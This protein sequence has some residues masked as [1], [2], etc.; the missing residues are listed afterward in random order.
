MAGII[1]ASDNVFRLASDPEDMM[2]NIIE[3]GTHLYDGDPESKRYV[4]HALPYGRYNERPDRRV[5]QFVYHAPSAEH[6]AELHE[7]HNP[8]DAIH[9]VQG[10]GDDYVDYTHPDDDFW[11]ER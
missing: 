4:V 5:E 11:P 2:N 1:R 7:F 10:P 8:D 9:H 3:R 6:A